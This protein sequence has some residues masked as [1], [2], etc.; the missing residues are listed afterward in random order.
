MADTVTV[1]IQ[2]ST[3]RNGARSTVASPIRHPQ[4]S[5]DIHNAVKA[6]RV[7]LVYGGQRMGAARCMRALG[8]LGTQG[9][10]GE[11]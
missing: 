2:Y 6:D 3:Y 4:R 11:Q 9:V 5:E 7:V 1:C 10:W 8:G